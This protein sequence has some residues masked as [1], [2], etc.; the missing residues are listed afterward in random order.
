MIDNIEII[1][2]GNGAKVWRLNIVPDRQTGQDH[3]QGHIKNIAISETLDRVRIYGSIAKY[4]RGEN[5]TPLTRQEYKEA[6]HSLEMETGI[7]F[8]TAFIRRVEIGQSIILKNPIINY[9]QCFDSMAGV[10]RDPRDKGGVLESVTYST[11][12]GARAFCA[13]NKI[14]EMKDK[15]ATIPEL[16][17]GCNVLRLEYR[18]VKRQG[19]KKYLGNGKDITPYHLADKELYER[20]AGLYREFYKKIPKI[21][22]L[23]FLDGGQEVTPKELNDVIAESYRQTN[24][25]QYKVLLQGLKSRGLISTATYKRIK[26][27][28]RRNAL[29]YGFSDTNAH[30]VELNDKMLV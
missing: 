8:T 11:K 12:T 30:I 1:I 5:I 17:T 24:P 20:L 23:V 14:Q 22:R 10:T 13:Y 21:N 3:F 15:R 6:L 2:N 7:D 28:E 25:E 27:Q 19:I 29:N 16:F 18:L 26:A 9:L 4:Y